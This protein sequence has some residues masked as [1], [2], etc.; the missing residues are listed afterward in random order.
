MCTAN[1]LFS[2]FF[3]FFFVP[4]SPCCTVNLSTQ[5]GRRAGLE[6][7]ATAEGSHAWACSVEYRYQYPWA[8]YGTA[9]CNSIGFAS[10]TV[11]SKECIRKFSINRI[12]D[13]WTVSVASLL[14]SK[15]WKLCRLQW[16]RDFIL[17]KLE[18]IV[19]LRPGRLYRRCDC[20]ILFGIKWRTVRR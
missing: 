1:P 15:N 3:L 12:Y 11:Q 17:A 5:N 18:C 2:V 8:P 13:V 16:I 20:R 14:I 4:R 7:S 19:E 9:G 10:G 6:W